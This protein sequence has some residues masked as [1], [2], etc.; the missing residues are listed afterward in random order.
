M[1]AGLLETLARAEAARPV[2][3]GPDGGAI[4]AGALRATA[5][6]AASRLPPGE[7]ALH[8]HT[9]RASMFAAGLIAASLLG[10]ELA[11]LPHVQPDYLRQLGVTPGNLLT[12]D[13]DQPILSSDT[14]SRDA[15]I[16]L[17][18]LTTPPLAFY[19]SGSTS[20]PKKAVKALFQ[21]E[22]EAHAWCEI[23]AA[24]IDSVAGTVSHQHIYGCLFRIVAP[25]LAGWPSTDLQAFTWE[26]FVTQLGPRVLG[27]TSPAHLSRIPP[28]LELAGKTPLILLSSGQALSFE[29]ARDATSRFGAAP[30]E[31]LGSTE[32]GGVATR[33]STAPDQLWTP[34]ERVSIRKSTDGAL[35]VRS[36]YAGD[37]EYYPMGD[38][39][40]IAEDGRFRLLARADRIAKVEGKR[41]SLDRIE[42]ILKSHPGIADARALLTTEAGRERLSA[43]IVP[44]EGAR[45]RLGL[46]GPFRYSRVLLGDLSNQLEAAERPK[47]WRFVSSLPQTAQ[48]KV[49]QSALQAL[50]DQQPVLPLLRASGAEIEAEEAR[51]S[52][53]MPDDLPW[54]AGHFPGAPL[55]PGLAQV[56]IAARLAEEIWAFAPCNHQVARM[57]FHR[58]LFPGDDVTLSITRL[59]EPDRIR[60]IYRTGAAIASEGVIGATNPAKPAQ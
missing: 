5:H 56:H 27:V 49:T 59:H 36:P 57:K 7:G 10:R 11:I 51:I 30:I 45:Q 46:L 54:F 17:G 52:F 53:S 31:I 8:L 14:A 3:V 40:E 58:V 16:P 33:R 9:N 23:F 18:D 37:D 42:A 13:G 35:E 39:V 25:I 12:D 32:T 50:F 28:N 43:V 47:R 22:L 55:L 34:L 29:A 20:A 26:T 4:T 41:V 44:E 60:Y 38:R 24:Q 1:S 19:T 48:A 6:A 2:F 15:T 21:L